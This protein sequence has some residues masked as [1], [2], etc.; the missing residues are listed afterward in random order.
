M[1]RLAI[2]TV[3][4]LVHAGCN[5]FESLVPEGFEQSEDMPGDLAIEDAPADLPEEVPDLPQD[6]PS[7]EDT[8]P[9]MT[10]PDMPQEMSPPS[11][12]V[13]AEDATRDGSPASVAPAAVVVANPDGTATKEFVVARLSLADLVQRA[14]VIHA[15]SDESSFQ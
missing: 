1:N 5:L 11:L 2:L 3:L 9:E 7:P 6:L 12:C 13:W 4:V 15:G 10:P 8:T 14:V